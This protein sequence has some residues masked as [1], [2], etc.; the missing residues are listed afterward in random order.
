VKGAVVLLDVGTNDVRGTRATARASPEVVADRIGKTIRALKEKGARAVIICEIKPM[1]F[2]DVRPYCHAIHLQCLEH[3]D[4]FGC[5]TQT[6]VS[7]L[8]EDGYH[9]QPSFLGVLDLT[10]ACALM[11]VPVPCLTPE[12]DRWAIKTQW[13]E[14]AEWPHVGEGRNIW[15]ERERPGAHEH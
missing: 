4:V 14:N 3:R 12:T 13:N 9:I 1:A 7:H 11:G 5:E 10:Y 15:K 6:G 8:K 2:M